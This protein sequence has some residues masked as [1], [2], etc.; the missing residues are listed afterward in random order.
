MIVR[1]DS[2]D[3]TERSDDSKYKIER[4]DVSGQGAEE[5][6]NFEERVESVVEYSSE[7]ICRLSKSFPLLETYFNNPATLHVLA[8]LSAQ[9]L[10]QLA[11]VS[12]GFWHA[13]NTPLLW[14][15]LLQRDFKLTEVERTRIV[16]GPNVADPM[17]PQHTLTSPLDARACASRAYYMHK[18]DGL[19]KRASWTREKCRGYKEKLKK[20]SSRAR[21]E[22]CLDFMLT[23]LFL[24]FMLAS[25]LSCVLLLAMWIDG[26]L[27]ISIFV[28]LSPFL[29]FLVYTLLC[30]A[31]TVCLLRRQTEEGGWLQSRGAVH[32]LYTVMFEENGRTAVVA[33]AA[34]LLLLVQVLVLG[35][36]LGSHIAAALQ[37][38]VVLLPLWLLFLLALTTPFLGCIQIPNFIL[39][40]CLLWVPFFVLFICLSLKLKGME[41][42][43]KYRNLRLALIFIP[44]WVLEGCA[45]LGSLVALAEVVYR[46]RQDLRAY[47]SLVL[48]KAG[49]EAQGRVAI[50]I[51]RCLCNYTTEANLHCPA[52]TPGAFALVWGLLLP[53]VISQSLASALDDGAG[54]ISALD[55][56]APL[57]FLLTAFFLGAAAFSCSH[58]TEFQVSSESLGMLVVMSDIAFAV[59][60]CCSNTAINSCWRGQALPPYL[61]YKHK[62]ANDFESSSRSWPW[63]V[64]GCYVLTG[65]LIHTL[66]W[67]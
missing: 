39:L 62:F 29:V 43:T 24:P 34:L 7:E 47:Y 5:I 64:W 8:H 1:D 56:A 66:T 67:W 12:V 16:E 44:F 36:K 45:M 15:E 33:L 9:E 2:N 63:I 23:R 32:F 61:K 30:C 37:W 38:E 49:A 52:A 21:T 41:N 58:I 13:S 4:S 46:L 22:S 60:V 28:C 3:M 14:K 10:T 51:D 48:E 59:C 42:N 20:D 27:H 55:I 25:G 19:K 65:Q 50:E 35:L 6:G 18:L 17:P 40:F 26:D 54:G 11:Y 31:F 53:L 57:L